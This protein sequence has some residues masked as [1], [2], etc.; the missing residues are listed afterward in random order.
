MSNFFWFLSAPGWNVSMLVLVLPAG[1]CWAE[2]FLILDY[3]GMVVGCE[4]C[5]DDE[6]Y[7]NDYDDDSY[8]DYANGDDD[9]DDYANGN[10][11]VD[12]SW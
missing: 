7:C 8:D 5:Y 6:Y 11:E 12:D 9:S 2:Y 1:L 4:H 3:D 10:D